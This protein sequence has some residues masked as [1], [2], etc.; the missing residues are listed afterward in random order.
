M[1]IGL[2]ITDR[3]LDAL[4]KGIKTYLPD[5]NVATWPNISALSSCDFI[6]T[7]RQP[8]NIWK[9]LPNT[10]I[11]CSLG[12]G[13]DGIINDKYLPKNAKIIRIVDQSLSK[14][15][16][17]YVLGVILMKRI[18]LDAYIKQQTKVEWLPKERKIGNKVVL[19]GVGKL[20]QVV[21][22][23]LQLNGFEVFGWSRTQKTGR[24]FVARY[25][26]EQLSPLLS[27]ADYVVSTLPATS[28]TFKFVNDKLF[29]QMSTQCCFINVGRGST[30]DE[31]ALISALDSKIIN[32]AVLDVMHTEPLNKSH[33]FWQH[34]KVTL[35]PHIAAITDQAQVVKQIV[36]NYMAFKSDQVLKN[37]VDLMLGY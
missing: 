19:L 15:M 2:L 6:V 21:G 9:E 11:V 37:Q 3:N 4:V 5:I 14:Q 24:P 28:S 29:K 26:E 31:Q 17:D 12:A 25:G 10:Q 33:P 18:Q 1:T 35:T 16:A 20:G 30:V 8:S 7:W 22:E 23:T 34:P 27:G 13:V 36:D 32:S